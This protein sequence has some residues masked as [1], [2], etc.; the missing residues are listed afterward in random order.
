MW[1]QRW[2]GYIIHLS[3]SQ[4]CLAIH[5][6][7]KQSL[8]ISQTRSIVTAMEPKTSMWT[9]IGRHVCTLSFTQEMQH[10]AS[11]SNNATSAVGRRM[12]RC[13]RYRCNDKMIC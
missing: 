2:D 11:D 12:V 13:L 4:G 3:T 6:K 7:K 8:M 9:L 1:P 5:P 10:F